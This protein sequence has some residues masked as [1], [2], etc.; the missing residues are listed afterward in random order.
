MTGAPEEIV[1]ADRIGAW[2]WILES[3]IAESWSRPWPWSA[4]S[5]IAASWLAAAKSLGAPAR[6]AA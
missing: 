5:R 4:A 3:P 2:E 6:L 1:E